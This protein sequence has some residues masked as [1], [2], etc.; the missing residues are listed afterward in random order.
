MGSRIYD[1]ILGRFLQADPF[2]QAPHNT[3]NYN[4]YSYVLNSLVSHTD[5]SGY[6]HRTCC[7][8]SATKFCAIST[9]ERNFFQQ[10]VLLFLV[11]LQILKKPLQN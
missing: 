7:I 4:R 10:K 2:V 3:Q 5:P 9:A 1:P 8:Y 11:K 6:L